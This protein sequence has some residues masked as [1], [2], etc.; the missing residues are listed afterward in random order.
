MRDYARL[1]QFALEGGKGVVPANWFAD[2]TRA[3][4]ATGGPPGFGYGYQWWTYPGGLYGAQGIF[5][6]SILVDPAKRVVI[7]MVSAWPKATGKDQ[8]A[9]RFAFM[10]K[11]LAAAQ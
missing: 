1:G 6:Q 2:A 10:G 3:H 9:A 5:G 7:A 4:A 11:L 8:S